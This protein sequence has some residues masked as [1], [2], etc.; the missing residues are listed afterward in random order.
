MHSPKTR[1]ADFTNAYERFDQLQIIH[2]QLVTNHLDAVLALA[3]TKAFVVR[4]DGNHYF[5]VDHDGLV[6]TCVLAV[7]DLLDI[8][9]FYSSSP[10][11]LLIV[12]Q[13]QHLFSLSSLVLL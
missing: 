4:R 6:A 8:S 1:L 12:H 11:L 9:Q 7:I 5:L 13:F 10:T 3:H 2:H